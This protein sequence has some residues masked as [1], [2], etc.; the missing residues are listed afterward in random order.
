MSGL[1]YYPLPKKLV[2]NEH[3]CA[4]VGQHYA[5]RRISRNKLLTDHSRRLSG[6]IPCSRH[7]WTKNWF[8]QLLKR[9]PL[10]L[11]SQT[12]CPTFLRQER[13]L[14][15]FIYPLNMNKPKVLCYPMLPHFRKGIAV[16][17][18]PGF[19]RLSFW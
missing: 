5:G 6:D 3:T 8:T 19:A 18:S 1:V 15:H 17:K 14:S 10:R 16:W 9:I 13:I 11:L 2:I 12:H 7:G 4:S